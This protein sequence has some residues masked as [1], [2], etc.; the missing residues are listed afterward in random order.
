MTKRCSIRNEY[1]LILDNNTIYLQE[2]GID[3][4]KE[5]FNKFLEDADVTKNNTIFI[6][7]VWKESGFKHPSGHLT[8]FFDYA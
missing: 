3:N 4:L 5:Y 6:Y 2:D 1:K 7:R 8:L